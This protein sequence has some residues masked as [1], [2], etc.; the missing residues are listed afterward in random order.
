M[1]LVH[2][3]DGT[4]VAWNDEIRPQ[5]THRCL[6]RSEW[7]QRIIVTEAADLPCEASQV[8]GGPSIATLQAISAGAIA[9]RA[10]LS[11]CI[12]VT[13][14][15]VGWGPPRRSSYPTASRGES[16]PTTLNFSMRLGHPLE[17][18]R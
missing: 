13:S 7:R 2:V 5:I 16:R 1:K 14:S 17:G 18:C 6:Q 11:R 3:P 10:V 9:R 12:V 8:A 15:M 4:I